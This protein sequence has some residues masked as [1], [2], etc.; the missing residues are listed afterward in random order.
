VN[1]FY[2]SAMV[3]DRRRSL[4]A[5]AQQSRMA[6]RAMEGARP[7]VGEKKRTLRWRL[8]I[9]HVRFGAVRPAVGEI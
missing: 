8:L 2:L 5:A 4:T 9:P 6:R 7:R 3:D 1:E